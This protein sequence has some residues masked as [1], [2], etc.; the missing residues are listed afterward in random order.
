MDK[1]LPNP[2][3]NETDVI[4]SNVKFNR[5]E[6]VGEIIIENNFNKLPFNETLTDL[7][8]KVTLSHIL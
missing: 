5:L 3:L 6:V 1:F 7:I 2:T 4:N 8:Y